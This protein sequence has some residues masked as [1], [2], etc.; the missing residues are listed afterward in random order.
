MRVKMLLS[1]GQ[2]MKVMVPWMKKDLKAHHWQN[3]AAVI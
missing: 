2:M 1:D 3:N